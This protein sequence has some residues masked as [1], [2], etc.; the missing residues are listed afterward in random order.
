MKFGE[1]PYRRMTVEDF[2]TSFDK[3]MREFSAAADAEGQLKAVR[4][5]FHLQDDLSTMENLAY[6]RHTVNTE[7]P[8]YAD[9]MEYIGKNEPKFESLKTVFRRALLA[10]P[11]RAALEKKLGGLYF[12]NAEIA[13]RAFDDK[14][15]DDMAEENRLELQYQKLIAAAQ[16]E[17]EGKTLNLSQLGYYQSGA[18]RALRKKAYD[19]YTGYL[20]AHAEELDDLYGRLVRSRDAQAKKLGYKNFIEL[21][22]LRMNRNSYGPGDVK[23]FRSLV[24]EKLVPVT[25][26][27]AARQK[28]RLGVDS[29]LFYDSGV[30]FREGNPEPV[31]T[32]EQIFAN[33]LRMYRELSPQTGDFFRFMLD[34]DLFDALAKKGK[35]SGGYCE[36]IPNYRSPFIFAN[37]NGSFDDIGTLTHEVGHA[38]QSYLSR[39]FE[40]PDY[41]VPT[42]ESA[43]IDSMSMEF[44]T[45][46][47]MELFFGKNADR[48][49]Y[50]HLSG[51]LMFIPYG[52]TVDEFQHI[53]YEN[54]GLSPKERK[55]AWRELERQYQPH[56]DYGDNRFYGGGGKWQRQQHIYLNP[57][58]YIDYCLAQTCALEFWAQMRQNRPEAWERY[59]ALCRLGGSE[60]FTGLLGKV[61]LDSPFRPG[62]LE[63]VSAA[64]ERFLDGF[65]ENLLN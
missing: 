29:L 44:F 45:W 31:G 61:G 6:I 28:A 13:L 41:R 24:R 33:G 8:F 36:D 65:D 55:N 18:D 50:M 11:H 37:F 32:P 42:M 43:E 60:T 19:T 63:T 52:C 15:M 51:T 12:K 17:F 4:A 64:A 1:M 2:K 5:F 56:L 26:K 23:A 47:W 40:V 46:P 3:M 39:D 48:Y 22:Y 59:V 27:I 38:F 49:R 16:V 35:A 62:C 21:G 57:F 9:E 25:Q 20:E 14:I 58:Y 53:V 7:D 54:P 34:R 10:S 30:Y